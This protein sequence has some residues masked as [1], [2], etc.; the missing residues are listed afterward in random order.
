MLDTHAAPEGSHDD[1]DATCTAPA[2]TRLEP[3]LIVNP[4]AAVNRPLQR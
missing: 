4:E 2:H 3:A 1:A